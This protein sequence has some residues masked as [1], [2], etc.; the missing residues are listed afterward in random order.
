MYCYYVFFL[1]CVCSVV[2]T[3]DLN[4]LG[5]KKNQEGLLKLNYNRATYRERKQ[6]PIDFD[7][8]AV[9]IIVLLWTAGFCQT[10]PS[11]KTKE[12]GHLKKTLT[13]KIKTLVK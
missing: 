1:F 3:P 8:Q 10:K 9:W 7:A 2:L 11:I 6:F 13:V 5:L 4:Y 12:R